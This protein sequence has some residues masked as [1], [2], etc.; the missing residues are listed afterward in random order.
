L[1]GKGSEPVKVHL[2]GEAEPT[3]LSLAQLFKEQGGV[4]S[5]SEGVPRDADLFLFRTGHD[6]IR[7]LTQGLVVLDLRDDVDL[8]AAVWASYADVCVVGD[9]SAK[10]V[11]VKVHGCE[12]ERVFV[13]SDNDALVSI[14]NRAARGVLSPVEAEKSSGSMADSQ[15]A[16]DQ[17]DILPAQQIAALAVR[18]ESIERQ[19]DVMLR[20]YQ[21][22]SKVPLIGLLIAWLR[23]N[24]TS[25][26]REPYLDP[27]LERQVALNRELVIVVREVLRLQ[28]N[29]DARL[30][31]LEEERSDE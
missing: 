17:A 29:L 18:I 6:A 16:S 3:L 4:V 13:V 21:V 9:A 10:T 27:I 14:V 23:R 11:L 26:L 15:P 31:R 28:T 24:L 22:R 19:T 20:S 5:H 25:H 12:Q 2:V 30:A 7:H 1:A 8:E